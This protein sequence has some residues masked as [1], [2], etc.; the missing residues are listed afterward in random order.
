MQCVHPAWSA[1]GLTDTLP[2]GSS[3]AGALK[4]IAFNK[5][6]HQMDRV[7]VFCDPIL[8]D[9]TPDGTK[10]MAT[11]MRNMYFGQN[12]ESCIVGDEIDIYCAYFLSHP[13]K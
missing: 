6:F 1:F 7:S 2:V 5:G 13:I 10:K 11:Q 4:E 12:Q 9:A 8:F 3:V